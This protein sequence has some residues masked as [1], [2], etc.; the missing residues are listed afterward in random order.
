MR[1]GGVA[2]YTPAQL[3][4]SFGFPEDK[5]VCQWC[6]FC[7]ASGELKRYVCR[8]TGELLPFPFTSRGMRC[9]VVFDEE[10]E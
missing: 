5:T 2:Y 1:D 4:Y 7:Y 3:R 8:I 10:A 9:P 6:P